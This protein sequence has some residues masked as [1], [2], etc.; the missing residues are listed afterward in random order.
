M[1]R[2]LVRRRSR[3]LNQPPRL[4]GLD[5]ADIGAL[6]EKIAARYL[7]AHGGKVLYR[8]Y[9]APMGG[10]IDIVLRHGKVLA[11]VEVKT[12]T[13][14]AFGRAAD[15]VDF[16]KQALIKRGAHSWLRQLGYPNI[17]WRC[18]ILEVYLKPERPPEVNWLQSAFTISDLFLRRPRVWTG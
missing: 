3:L 11:F 13:S 7:Y 4:V 5:T 1:I 10:E 6:G 9:R 2:Y 8:N 15:A 12:R 14:D 18:D 16:H 17:P